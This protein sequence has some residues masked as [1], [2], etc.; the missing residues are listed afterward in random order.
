MSNAK[1]GWCMDCS[2]LSV[3]VSIDGE[4]AYWCRATQH[5]LVGPVAWRQGCERFDRLFP[6]RS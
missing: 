2:W 4:S 6:R 1:R 3:R 5:R